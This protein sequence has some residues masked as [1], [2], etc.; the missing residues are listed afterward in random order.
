[1]HRHDYKRT[2]TGIVI[3]G[4]YVRKP[5]APTRDAEVIQ[6][7]LLDGPRPSVHLILDWWDRWSLHVVGG[8]MVAGFVIGLVL[9]ACA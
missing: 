4:H 9:K 6:R 7:S 1:M 2:S 8:I 5:P 3:G